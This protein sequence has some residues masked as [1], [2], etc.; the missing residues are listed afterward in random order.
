[1]KKRYLGFSI[2]TSFTTHKIVHYVCIFCYE[3]ILKALSKYF[4][5]WIE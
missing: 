5:S 2:S 1:M 3:E 4:V